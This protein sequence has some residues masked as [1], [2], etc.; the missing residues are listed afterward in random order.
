MHI[1]NA[2]RLVGYSKLLF[3]LF[4]FREWE[5]FLVGERGRRS[6]PLLVDWGAPGTIGPSAEGSVEAAHKY[7]YMF[8]VA[9]VRGRCAVFNVF[10]LSATS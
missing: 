4:P 3:E 9:D 2:L 10:V 6:S 7:A 1:R 8:F 5:P